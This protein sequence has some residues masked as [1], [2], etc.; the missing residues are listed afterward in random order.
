[1]VF[2]LLP[3]KRSTLP[4]GYIT[5]ARCQL[6]NH[7]AVGRGYSNRFMVYQSFLL[8]PKISNKNT[9]EVPKIFDIC[10]TCSDLIDEGD[11]LIYYN[12]KYI[13]DCIFREND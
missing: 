1:M 5:Y 3:H 2:K 6:C 13:V 9:C 12:K 4:D 7:N 10:D 11:I 8:E